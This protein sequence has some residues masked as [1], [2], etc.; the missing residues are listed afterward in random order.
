MLSPDTAYTTVGDAFSSYSGDGA[1][2]P[3]GRV[4]A[5]YDYDAQGEEEL[6]FKEGD[7]ITVLVK[8]DENWWLGTLHGRK[9]MFPCTYVEELA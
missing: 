9:G 8:E 7:I 1:E 4:R 3:I 5:L 2:E 6:T